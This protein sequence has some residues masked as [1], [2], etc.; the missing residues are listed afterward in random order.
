MRR[1]VKYVH[2][3]D[4]MIV[5]TLYFIGLHS[6]EEL[7]QSI[8]GTK[9]SIIPLPEKKKYNFEADSHLKPTTT[10][11][12][13]C[14][15]DPSGLAPAL[16]EKAQEINFTLHLHIIGNTAPVPFLHMYTLIDYKSKS[17]QLL[18]KKDEWYEMLQQLSTK[19][20]DMM[21]EVPRL[22]CRHDKL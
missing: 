22:V 1:S 12:T 14:G 6:L 5:E 16:Q 4:L 9:I 7:G 11:W 19:Y 20:M 2:L 17:I 10:I 21:N 3:V 18:P 8:G 15:L 13:N